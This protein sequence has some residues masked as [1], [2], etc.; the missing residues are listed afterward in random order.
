MTVYYF[1]HFHRNVSLFNPSNNKSKYNLYCGTSRRQQI[2]SRTCRNWAQLTI[3]KSTVGTG[4]D[5]VASYT[6]RS[7]SDADK[8]RLLK[9]HFQP[10]L[11]YKFPMASNGRS[12]QHKGCS[13]NYP[14]GG[15]HFF[16]DP[17]TPRTH[18]ES[19][20][21]RPPGHVTRPTMDQIR[22]DRQ[23]KLPPHPSDTLSTKHPPPT[24]GQKSACGPPTPRGWF[25]EQP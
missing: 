25:L 20:P 16:S 14:G 7:V 18:V 4:C 1:L 24:T 17:S 2:C 22:L 8:C 10:D 6:G 5:D 12:F 23:D 21:P 9:H 11:K 15:L 13:R 19:D 3:A